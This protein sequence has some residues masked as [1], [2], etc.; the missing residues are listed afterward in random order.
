MLTE[1]LWAA[2]GVLYGLSIRYSAISRSVDTLIL[3]PPPIC[4]SGC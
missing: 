2:D 4:I 3:E 1:T